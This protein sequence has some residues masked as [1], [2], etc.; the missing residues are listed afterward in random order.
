LAR[1]NFALHADKL[2]RLCCPQPEMILGDSRLLCHQLAGLMLREART[3]CGA[4]TSPP[5]ADIAAGAGGLNTKPPRNSSDQSGRN[6]DAPSQQ[7]DQHYGAGAITSPPYQDMPVEGTGMTSKAR[8]DPSHKNYRPSWVEKAKRGYFEGKVQG[9]VTSPPYVSGGH[10]TDVFD[11]WNVN[12]RGQQIKK[13]TAGYGKNGAQ[14]GLLKQGAYWAA[15]EAVYSQLLQALRPGGVF[16][17]VV[18]DYVKGG[19]RMALCDDTWNLLHM[20]GFQHLERI[21][22]MLVQ[23]YEHEDLFTGTVKSKTERKSFFRRLAESKGSP[24]IDFEEV[25]FVMKPH[26]PRQEQLP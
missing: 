23:E 10:H 18:K 9:S 25:L 17:V 11:A 19:K 12:S 8:L 26:Q 6:A 1:R 14:I 22:A 3:F 24:A 5:Y 15:M 4:V 16:C 21:R 20:I 7:A 13:E 2:A